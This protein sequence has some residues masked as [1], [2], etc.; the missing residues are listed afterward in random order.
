MRA[1]FCLS[2]RK[3][4]QPKTPSQVYCSLNCKNKRVKT[5]PIFIKTIILFLLLTLVIQISSPNTLKSDQINKISGY[6]GNTLSL[7]IK[8]IQLDFKSI[9]IIE[10]IRQITAEAGYS[11]SEQNLWVEI[12]RLESTFN[13]SARG[14]AG[15]FFGLYQ[16]FLG[17][18][19]G[20]GCQGDI[21]NS[22]DN[23]RCAIKIERVEGFQPWEAYTKLL[24]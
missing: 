18:W 22:A 12:A 5:T 11:E 13:P 19:N 3:E 17:T 10:Q 9:T 15:N 2:C 4:Y 24:K 6:S 14:Y 20:Y 1:R 23:L 21:F 16:I 8:S 7:E